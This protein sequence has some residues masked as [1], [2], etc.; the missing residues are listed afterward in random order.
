MVDGIGRANAIGKHKA[1]IAAI[2]RLPEARG[3]AAVSGDT[4]QYQ[5]SNA[6]AAKDRVDVGRGE[7]TVARLVQDGL[8]GRRRKLGD[9]LPARLA[10]DERA[11]HGASVADCDG[12]VRAT[13][14]LPGLQ[15]REVGAVA[16]ARVHHMVAGAADRRE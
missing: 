15:I 13:T 9:D 12:I 4:S 3:D 2:E 14:P 7:G 11:A 5:V 10:P 1:V 8:A 16:F 6:P